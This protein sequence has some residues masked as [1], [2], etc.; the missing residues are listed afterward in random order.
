MRIPFYTLCTILGVAASIG[1]FIWAE[2]KEGLRQVTVN[3]MIFT[4]LIGFVVMFLSA[5]FF[6]SLFHTIETGEFT[7]GGITWLGGVIGVFVFMIIG[8]HFW[9]PEAKGNAFKYFSLM[10]PGLVIGHAFGRVGCFMAGCCF[11]RPTDSFLGVVFP[12]NS[13]AARLYGYG[14]AVLPTQLFEAVFELLFF[15]AMVLTWKKTK[16]FEVEIYM[17]VYGVFRFILEFFRGDDRGATGFFLTPAQFFCVLMIVAG[18]TIILMRKGVALK[19]LHAKTLVWQKEAI[20]RMKI[21]DKQVEDAKAVDSLG[22][23]YEL[24]QKGIITEKEFETK[25]KQL[26]D[27]I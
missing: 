19:K 10:I 4:M 5:F 26:L 13:E 17:I 7:L 16:Y 12:E 24:R 3:R 18:V 2:R 11:G 27:K 14:T 15:I 25:K 8:F 1:W 21:I 20:E 23:L 6:N 9:V 22:K